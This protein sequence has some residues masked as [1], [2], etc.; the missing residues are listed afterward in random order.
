[1]MWCLWGAIDAFGAVFV[2]QISHH[3]LHPHGTVADG[4]KQHQIA[5]NNDNN[6]NNNNN[7]INLAA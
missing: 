3:G 6:N 1:M 4:A 5:P 7:N 2:H